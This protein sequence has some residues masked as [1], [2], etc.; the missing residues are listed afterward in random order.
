MKTEKEVNNNR[1][2][3]LNK[4]SI[5]NPYVISIHGWLKVFLILLLGGGVMALTIS[6]ISLKGCRLN[7]DT[8]QITEEANYKYFVTV[9]SADRFGLYPTSNCKWTRVL[10]YF[11]GD[12]FF[13]GI[14]LEKYG[15][16]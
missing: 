7:Y 12:R 15:T 11:G 3:D 10:S 4:D 1:E 2:S 16:Y 9:F 5:P 13:Q 6:W 14:L 8:L